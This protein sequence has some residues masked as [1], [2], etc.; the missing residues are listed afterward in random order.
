MRINRWTDRKD[1]FSALWKK[2]TIIYLKTYLKIFL[3]VKNHLFINYS[4]KNKIKSIKR[5]NGWLSNTLRKTTPTLHTSYSILLLLPE[6]IH[7]TKFCDSRPPTF[8]FHTTN[9]HLAHSLK[10][11]VEPSSFFEQFPDSSLETIRKNWLVNLSSVNIPQDIQCLLQ[12][13]ENFSLPLFNKKKIIIELIKSVEN[14][15]QKFD[16]ETQLLPAMPRHPIFHSQRRI[17]IY[18]LVAGGRTARYSDICDSIHKSDRI[19]FCKFA[20]PSPPYPISRHD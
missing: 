7:A 8:T 19:P 4:Q 15:T 6:K 16:I 20:S 10:I 14:I 5:L 9:P 3:I 12:L 13:G 17:L 18:I 2:F 11:N 1:K